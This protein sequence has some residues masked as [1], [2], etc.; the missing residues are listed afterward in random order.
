M[1]RSKSS[2]EDWLLQ[3]SADFG[4][5]NTTRKR[6]RDE[7]DER[8]ER[9]N[10]DNHIDR[11]GRDSKL[12]SPPTTLY[13]A[14]LP[15][16]LSMQDARCTT[17]IRSGKRRK[18]DDERQDKGDGDGNLNSDADDEDPTPRRRREDISSRGIAI[19]SGPQAS[20]QTS[21]STG[22]SQTWSVK[23]RRKAQGLALVSVSAPQLAYFNDPN[24]KPPPLLH[25]FANMLED[26]DIDKRFV[27]PELQDEIEQHPLKSSLFR[28]LANPV[29][30][31]SREG[32]RADHPPR[33][34]SPSCSQL[35]QLVEAARECEIEHDSEAQWN[36]AVHYPLL[37]LALGPHSA[38]LRA[39][40]C[41]SATINSEYQ[42]PQPR[43]TSVGSDAKKADFCIV[44]RQP[45]MHR[46]PSIAEINSAESINH[47]NHP[48]LLSNPIVISIETKA[49]APN[50]EEAELQMGV[51]MAAHFARLRALVVCQYERR[52]SPSMPRQDVFAVE[53]EWRRAV[54]KLGFLPGL[55]VLQHQWFFVAAT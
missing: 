46:H 44:L 40:N 38:N 15:S 2:I 41:T 14:D 50:Q 21:E 3:P 7:S 27:W 42:T 28:R 6:P 55:L 33:G 32:P 5:A 52:P 43:S 30:Y 22:S 19:S 37:A 49:A 54:E 25:E 31:A 36:C 48:P 9:N 45:S 4:R 24:S 18:E 39:L 20:I 34:S 11:D 10:W 17:P 26:M 12:P 8:D 13:I 23:R 1:Y 29:F 53:T 35:Q 16:S 51:W 47:S